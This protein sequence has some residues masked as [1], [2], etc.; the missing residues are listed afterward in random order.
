VGVAPRHL[1]FETLQ[2]SAQNHVYWLNCRKY[3]MNS[4][5]SGVAYDVNAQHNFAGP[6]AT[7]R[8]PHL[9]A[10]SDNYYDEQYRR[11]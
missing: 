11:D 5:W 10:V 4:S 9:N 7:C 8:Q 6:A 3:G 2:L 1:D